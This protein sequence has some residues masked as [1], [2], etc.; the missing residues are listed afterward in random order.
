MRCRCGRIK[1]AEGELQERGSWLCDFC[2]GQ[3]WTLQ[4]FG[5]VAP[6]GAPVQAAPAAPTAAKSKKRKTAPAR[7]R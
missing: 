3:G 5:F 4:P 7:K 2:Q 6:D 1:E